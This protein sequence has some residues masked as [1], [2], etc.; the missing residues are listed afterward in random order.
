MN[1]KPKSPPQATEWWSSLD[2]QW[3]AIFKEAIGIKTE[4]TAI[5]LVAILSL[6]KLDCHKKKLTSLE[7]LR[8]LTGLQ[9]LDCG[10][11]QLTSLEPLRACSGLQTLNCWRN[12][13]TSLEP[14]H[15]LKSL[16]QLE[17][18]NNPSLSQP[19][20][21]RFLTNNRWCYRWYWWSSL[22][23]QWQAIFKAAIGIYSTHGK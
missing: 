1:T 15:G 2:A 16:K 3:Q 9:T 17:C 13:L 4:P 11:N 21:E 23:A 12:R 8:A 14:L 18:G 6:T 22:D 19:E 5:E 10:W 7:P 20:L